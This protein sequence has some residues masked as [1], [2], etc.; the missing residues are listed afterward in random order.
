MGSL[1]SSTVYPQN[2]LRVGSWGLR[3]SDDDMCQIDDKD[4]LMVDASVKL[5]SILVSDDLSKVNNCYHV[6]CMF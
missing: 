6:I 2:S 4:E 5:K 1:R 3:N